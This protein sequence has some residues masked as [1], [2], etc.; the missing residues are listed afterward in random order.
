MRIDNLFKQGLSYSSLPKLIH[1][2][3]RHLLLSPTSHRRGIDLIPHQLIANKNVR[4]FMFTFN[5][6]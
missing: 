5:E 4:L 2:H 3:A 1:A 6:G